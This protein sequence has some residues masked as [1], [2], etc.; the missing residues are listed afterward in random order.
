[1][2]VKTSDNA[3]LLSSDGEDEESRYKN[4]KSVKVKQSRYTCWI[5]PLFV[6]YNNWFS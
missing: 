5:G 3:Q 2:D 4:A 6:R 1:M